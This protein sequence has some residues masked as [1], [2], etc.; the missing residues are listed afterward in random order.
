MPT[1]LPEYQQ[2]IL[3]LLDTLAV[4]VVATDVPTDTDEGARCRVLLDML[5]G[6]LR[7]LRTD[8]RRGRLS[9][10]QELARRVIGLHVAATGVQERVA[11]I[12][13]GAMPAVG[14]A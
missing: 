3:T 6:T 12:R 7:R 4:L 5:D 13:A 9:D 14:E 11:V 10:P 8:I 1:T 2:R